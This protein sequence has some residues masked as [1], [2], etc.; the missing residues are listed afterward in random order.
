[1]CEFKCCNFCLCHYIN[2][3]YCNKKGLLYFIYSKDEVK[4]PKCGG[5]MNEKYG[6]RNKG[7]IK[8]NY[9]HE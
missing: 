4:C 3:K 1:M 5:P 7:Y 2:C 8:E 9:I 6:N